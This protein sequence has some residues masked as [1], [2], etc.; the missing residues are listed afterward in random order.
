MKTSH[1]QV[2]EQKLVTTWLWNS[3]LHVCF[4]HSKFLSQNLG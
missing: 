1:E 3:S 4:T 2:S